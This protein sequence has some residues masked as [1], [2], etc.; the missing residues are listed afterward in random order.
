MGRVES[1]HLIAEHSGEPRAVDAASAEA[2]LGLRGDRH[3]GDPSSS[4]ALTF[5]E[6]EVLEQLLAESGLDLTRGHS[7][8]NVMT[9]GAD[10][11]ELIGR[12]FRV[13]DAVCEGLKRNEPCEHL[14]GLTD[15]VILRGLVHTGL[16]ASIL[17]SGS[18]R[19]GDSLT[20]LPV[21][22]ASQAS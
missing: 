22:E 3:H 10:L 8:R 20:L 4:S 14:A 12:R 19:T 11:G 1:I 5:I 21:E 16:R 18:I 13:G 2:G 7:R 6:A 9:R 17:E 15:P